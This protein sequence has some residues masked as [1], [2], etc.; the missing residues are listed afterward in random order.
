MMKK[1]KYLGQIIAGKLPYPFHLSVISVF[2]FLFGSLRLKVLYDLFRRPDYAY[3]IYEA[4]TR[5]K[6][7]GLKGITVMEFGVANGRG[8]MAMIMYAEKVSK[9]LDIKI[10]IIGYDSGEGMPKFTDYKDHP[11]LYTWG[12]FPMVH[13]DQLLK[14]L[15]SNAKLVFLD[16][17]KESWLA[18]AEIE[19]P[20][21][22]IS[23]DVDYYSSTVGIINTLLE[24]DSNML[25]PNTL[26]YFDDVI[27]DNH[28]S[29][30]GELLAIKDFNAKENMR[31]IESYAQVLRHRRMFKFAYWIDNMYQLHVLDHR[32]R[33]NPYRADDA[34]VTIIKNKYFGS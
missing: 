16:L 26:M 11:E 5:A 23:V 7:L 31:K 18:A 4:A 17:I 9:A 8:L 28:N 32:Y 29:Y 22:F 20:I 15:P 6:A 34:P 2:V 33:K 12:D 24:I 10:N 1:L 14:F 19:Y 21:G 30:Q 3:G 13:R 25:M 27:L